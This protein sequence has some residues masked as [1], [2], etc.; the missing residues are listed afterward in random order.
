MLSLK[1]CS[2]TDQLPLITSCPVT[3]L[4]VEP[5]LQNRVL[6][7]IEDSSLLTCISAILTRRNSCLIPC[8]RKNL[9]FKL[10]S[11]SGLFSSPE[12]KAPGELI[13]YRLLINSLFGVFYSYFWAGDSC[14]SK[15][16]FKFTLWDSYFFQKMS[17]G[18]LFSKS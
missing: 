13:V 3:V 2:Q 11:A 14:F 8:S 15:N 10:K 6:M 5:Y 12:S 17:L 7:V 16:F 9:Q 18:L 1:T 4:T